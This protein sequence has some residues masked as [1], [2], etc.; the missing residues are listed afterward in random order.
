MVR[1]WTL[2]PEDEAW[3]YPVRVLLLQ[4]TFF[5][6]VT[7]VLLLIDP[8]LD[9]VSSNSPDVVTAAVSP[10]GFGS[11]PTYRRITLFEISVG[12]HKYPSPG[13]CPFLPAA[14]CVIARTQHVMICVPSD[15]GGIER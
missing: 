2:V 6:A 14:S 7:S 1:Q 15:K 11:L 9:K 10:F 3:F 4:G 5:L 13:V 12:I 8:A